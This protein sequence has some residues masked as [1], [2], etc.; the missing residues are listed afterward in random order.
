MKVVLKNRPRIRLDFRFIDRVYLPWAKR[1]W[2][3]I[4]YKVNANPQTEVVA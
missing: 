3:Q 1:V 4:C 2:A